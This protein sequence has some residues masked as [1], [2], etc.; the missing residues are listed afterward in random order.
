VSGSTINRIR[1]T[2]L[3]SRFVIDGNSTVNGY[4][5]ELWKTMPSGINNIWYYP[6]EDALI[7][8]LDD[9]SFYKYNCEDGAEILATTITGSLPGA[10]YKNKQCSNFNNGSIAWDAGSDVREI[11]LVFGTV[12]THSGQGGGFF[13]SGDQYDSGSKSLVGIGTSGS[14][15]NGSGQ[16]QSMNNALSRLFFDRLGDDR[17]PLADFLEGVSIKAGYDPSEI[18]ISP[19]ID[20]EIDGAIISNVTT[21]R[22]IMEPMSVLYRF[23]MVESGGKIKFTRQP[24]NAPA[25]NFTI[26]S[27]DTLIN[28]ESDVGGITFQSRREEEREVPQR[29]NIRYIDK[30]LSYQWA[31]QFSTRSQTI[32][33]NQSNTQITY[34][35]PIVM[36]AAEAKMISYR[37]LWTAW[38]SRVAYSF[39]V[40]QE[41][42][43]MEPGDIGTITAVGLQFTVKAVEV[44]YNN[45]FS[46]SVR[47]TGWL[48]DENFEVTAD[49]GDGYTQEIPYTTG[50]DAFIIDVP[51]LQPSQD[52]NFSGQ[53][54]VYV[55]IS[56]IIQTNTWGGGSMWA[57]YD[58]Y[59]FEEDVSSTV[60]GFVGVVPTPP[61]VPDSILQI[62]YDN[63]ITV[64][65]RQG[66][67][68]L[69]TSC[70]ELEMLAGA[71]AAAYGANG[72]WEIIQFQTVTDNGN[73]SF[74]L[75][76]LL[77][78]QRGTDYAVDNHRNGDFFVLLDSSW[79]ELITFPHADMELSFRYKGVGFGQDQATIP[80]SVVTLEGYGALPWPPNNLR[81][82][83]S[84]TALTG[85]ITI[86]WDR[87]S[88]TNGG[89]V[90]FGEY[91]DLASTEANDYLV[92]I[93]RWP[94]Y[95]NWTY[96]GGTWSP[97]AN[98]PDND[99]VT[100]EVTGATSLTLTA[101]QIR[102]A[103]LYEFSAPDNLTNPSSTFS[104]V[105]GAYIAA[106][107]TANEQ[108]VDLGFGEF[109]A[110]KSL[111]I[112]VQQKT[113]LPHSTGYGPGR[114]TTVMIED[115]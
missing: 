6:L 27:G 47:A 102:T 80:P 65:T 88:R 46:L 37:A 66:D 64:Y 3:A 107:E 59:N 110:F 20:D 103:E 79:V 21:F 76:N 11:D 89:L 109:V 53:F 92:S 106:N 54:P 97:G 30:S 58:G 14:G 52:L 8:L 74:I 18:E 91:A 87:R 108:I 71:N 84:R 9:G 17:I 23:D 77:R 67:S 7:V 68:T 28:S 43:K 33:T 51:L 31:M 112:M 60:E 19:S 10:H 99:V 85:D 22:D 113:N 111:E 82:T 29:V 73:G 57:A 12:T 13:A 44:T 45:D 34:E 69:M 90:D 105:S 50:A 42:L 61:V 15:S 63:T 70:T 95:D 25:T 1:L 62:D 93:R 86:A 38:Q 98:D 48:S 4:T 56:P 24:L 104:N 78:G 39:R 94:H 81:I 101:A 16:T 72:R 115:T 75:S 32:E 96:G 35:V 40:S 2:T 55:V 26:D 83:R 100:F 36:N 5:N 41:F 114:W 49:P